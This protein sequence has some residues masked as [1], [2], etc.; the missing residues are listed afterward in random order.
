MQDIRLKQLIVLLTIGLVGYLWW[1]H[2][3]HA[4]KTVQGDI[5]YH[6]ANTV[7]DDRDDAAPPLIIALHGNGDTLGNFRETLFHDLPLDA[8][9]VTIQGPLSYRNGYAW[10][11]SGPELQKYGDAL[12]DVVTQ[13]TDKYLPVRKPILV[14]FSGG[15]CMAYYQ[16]AMYPDLYTAIIPISGSLDPSMVQ[17]AA[18]NIDGAVI[19]ALHGRK[20]PVIPYTSGKSATA[21]LA[22]LGR[23]VRMTELP[24]EHL[25]AFLEG[26][27]TFLSTLSDAA[28]P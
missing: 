8:R 5:T 16:A 2:H 20:D 26:H 27:A 15:A 4:I 28:S 17:D 13:L 21:L 12:A 1:S 25:A 10:P 19:L 6:Y 22:G 23:D 24:G 7:F 3:P 9:L 18:A 14:G 11:L